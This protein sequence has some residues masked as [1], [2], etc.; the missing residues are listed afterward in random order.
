MSKKE[1]ASIRRDNSVCTYLATNITAFVG[2][3]AFNAIA[4]KTIAYY[5][6]TVNVATAAAADNTGYYLKMVNIR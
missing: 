5:A 6:L 4:T 1:N 3:V 2:D